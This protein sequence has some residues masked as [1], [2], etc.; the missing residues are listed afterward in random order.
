[1]LVF[2][3]GGGS[4]EHNVSMNLVLAIE[5]AREVGAAILGVVGSPT[6]R[7]RNSA[8]S[9]SSSTLRPR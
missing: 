1:M 9:W 6:A 4:R 8:T 5:P 7:P 2:S 3:V